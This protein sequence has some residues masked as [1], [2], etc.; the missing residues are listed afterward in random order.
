[1]GIFGYGQVISGATRRLLWIQARMSSV[2]SSIYPSIPLPANTRKIG[3]TLAFAQTR[4]AKLWR[5]CGGI[6]NPFVSRSSLSKESQ[7]RASVRERESP[8]T[9]ARRNNTKACEDLRRSQ[10]FFLLFLHN[11]H[12]S[13]L[14]GNFQWTSSTFDAFLQ[15]R[16]RRSSVH[17]IAGESM[18]FWPCFFVCFLKRHLEL[19]SDFFFLQISADWS[20]KSRSEPLDSADPAMRFWAF[21]ILFF[22]W[23]N[24]NRAIGNGLESWRGVWKDWH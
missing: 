17:L 13:S 11:A 23:E 15:W 16:K 1:V 22:V 9:A 10:T 5:N 8:R 24:W 6:A 2:H 12:H 3:K 20:E 19:W 14:S 21:V 7:R 18:C 4:L